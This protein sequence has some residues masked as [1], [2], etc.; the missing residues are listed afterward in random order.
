M[1]ASAT[2]VSRRPQSE[3]TE[4]YDVINKMVR[5]GISPV[6][7]VL[8]RRSF[9]RCALNKY[10]G[11]VDVYCICSSYNHFYLTFMNDTQSQYTNKRLMASQ[12]I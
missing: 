11:K 5:F 10:L 9:K 3:V 7:P 4:V 8:V 12:I 1:S 2:T 6:L